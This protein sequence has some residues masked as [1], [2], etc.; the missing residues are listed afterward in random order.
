MK[1]NAFLF[2]FC[3]A[4]LA[5]LLPVQAQNKEESV[6]T[7][8]ALSLPLE[9][10]LGKTCWIMNYPD[11][12]AAS[13]AVKDAACGK[14]SYDGHKGTDFAIRDTKL[15]DKGVAVL[16]V[17]DGTVFRL[18]NGQEDTFKSDA[19]MTAIHDANLDC[20]NGVI[21]DN[22]D[23]WLTQYCHLKKNS[24]KVKEGD[25]VRRGQ[26]I[27]EVGMSGITQ[28]PHVHLTLI[29]K[30]EI[31]D[32]FTGA[33]TQNG[34]RPDMS[35]SLWADKTITYE[36]FVLYDMGFAETPPDFEGIAMGNRGEIPKT[37][38]P[39]FLVWFA[40]FGPEKGDR[41][42]V[43]VTAPSGQDGSFKE[44]MVQDLDRA[45]QFYYVGRAAPS[46]GF[47]RG[48]WKATVTISRDGLKDPVTLTRAVD[49]L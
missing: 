26:K 28:H 13:G 32:P 7:F 47:A 38:S 18:R 39:A 40:Y 12:D 4:L 16:S 22:G 45:R 43:E 44:E 24:L 8:L 15:M 6:D 23:G 42:T 19:E 48:T 3:A 34:C 14:R 11:D 27:A 33:P 41:I 17:A 30:G 49:V 10:R 37:H 46:G 20:G 5:G 35:G 31:I 29:H 9:C 25:K 21:I 1:Y 2:L 36:P